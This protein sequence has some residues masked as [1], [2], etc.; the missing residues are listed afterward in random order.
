M[1]SSYIL[2]RIIIMTTKYHHLEDTDL[3][4]IYDELTD[5]QKLTLCLR[6]FRVK[7][8]NQV[9]YRLGID[10]D[11]LEQSFQDEY[12]DLLTEVAEGL[13]PDTD[14]FIIP[15]AEDVIEECAC[16]VNWMTYC[17]IQDVTNYLNQR[18]DD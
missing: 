4:E 1:E 18:G 8:I 15:D 16:W 11:D 5:E 14:D 13:E 2:E 9:A 3:Q 10:L 7:T 6:D 17:D 12:D